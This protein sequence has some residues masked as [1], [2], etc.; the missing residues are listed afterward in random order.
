MVKI[1]SFLRMF[2]R[3]V[4]VMAMAMLNRETPSGV[5]LV[6]LGALL[7]FLSPIDFIPDSVPFLGFVDDAVIV[8]AAI[9]GLM[10]FLPPRVRRESE[11]RAAYLM[12][13]I[14][15]VLIGGTA[16]IVL[17][18]CLVIWTIYKIFS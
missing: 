2:R 15:W 16:V 7:Y 8:P 9:M 3:D 14:K 13:R 1:M 6:M 17:W 10:R 11:E 5:K 18:T 4:I 12:R